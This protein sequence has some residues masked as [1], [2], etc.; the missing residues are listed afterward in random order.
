VDGVRLEFKD[1]W[2]LIRSSNTEPE[3]SVRFE[4]TT[5]EKLEE[6]KSMVLKELNK[7]M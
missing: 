3:L 5:K 4:A 2:G 6:I 7:Q 1:G